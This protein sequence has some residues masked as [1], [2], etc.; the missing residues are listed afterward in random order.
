MDKYLC[1][2]LGTSIPKKQFRKES[3]KPNTIFCEVSCCESVFLSNV[4]QLNLA[5]MFW[6]PLF[7]YTNCKLCS[8]QTAFKTYR[9]NS[10]ILIIKQEFMT[11][12]IVISVS[13]LITFTKEYLVRKRSA[14]VQLDYM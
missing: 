13:A 10:L 6:I 3:N 8:A 11:K 12:L 5:S 2:S 14:Y 9:I 4:R 1:F 7:R